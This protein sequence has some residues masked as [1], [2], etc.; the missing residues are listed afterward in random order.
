VILDKVGA[1][2][3]KFSIQTRRDV[4]NYLIL[5][6]QLAPS[7]PIFLLPPNAPSTLKSVSSRRRRKQSVMSPLEPN[8]GKE[9]VEGG[10]RAIITCVEAEQKEPFRDL[11]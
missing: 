5:L 6:D 3:K 10:G 11:L 4:S 9:K 7:F 8:C 2:R 1:E